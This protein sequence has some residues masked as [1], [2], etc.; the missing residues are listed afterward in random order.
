MK[1]QLNLQD[2]NKLRFGL[3]SLRVSVFV[4]LL[5][6]TVDKFLNPSHALKIFDKF[7]YIS[8]LN[9]IVLYFIAGCEVILIFAFLFG[10][11]KRFTYGMVLVIHAISTLSSYKQYFSPFEGSNLLFFAAWPMLAACWVLYLMRQ[12]DNFLSLH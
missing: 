6:W 7:Y 1:Y 10:I 5:M 9:E 11:Y 8:N 3:F 12:E 4:V 2:R